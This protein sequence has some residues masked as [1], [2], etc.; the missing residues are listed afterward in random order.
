MAQARPQTYANP[1]TQTQ[2]YNPS[3][4]VQGANFQQPGHTNPSLN[5][6]SVQPQNNTVQTNIQN[7]S[8][9]YTQ[10]QAYQ[11][12]ESSRKRKAEELEVRVILTKQNYLVALG[13][14]YIL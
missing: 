13:S 11:Q 6:G 8:A 2:A 5:Q 4:N 7:G 9:Q 10:S 3:A 1:Q 14:N 12:D